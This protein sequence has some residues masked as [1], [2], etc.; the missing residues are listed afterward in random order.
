[1]EEH[2]RRPDSRSIWSD[3]AE[4]LV[5]HGV[6]HVFGLPGDDMAALAAL[7]ASG[8]TVHLVAD[9]RHAVYQAI[10]YG[11]LSGKVGVCLVGKGPAVTHAATGVLEAQTM[12]SPLVLLTSGL[13]PSRLGSRGF[14]E[15]DAVEVLRPIS[16]WTKRVGEPGAIQQDVDEAVWQ[17]LTGAPGAACL[18]IPEGMDSAGVTAGRAT[19]PLRRPVVPE[20][21]A[22]SGMLLDAQRPVLLVGGGCREAGVGGLVTELA[23]RLG[24]AILC[25]A[26]GR[27][28]VDESCPEFLGL[29][30]LYA[31]PAAAEVFAKA[32]LVVAL[33]S[34]LEETATYGWPGTVPPVLQVNRSIDDVSTRWPGAAVVADVGAVLRSWLSGPL[35]PVA[36]AAPRAAWRAAV[37]S[38]RDDLVNGLRDRRP[39]PSPAT[40]RVADVLAALEEVLPRERVSVHE[41]GLQDMWSYFFPTWSVGAGADCLVPSEQTPLGFGFGSA[42]G[43]ALAAGARPVVVIGGDGAFTAALSDLGTLA[44]VRHPLLLVVLSNGGFGWLEANLRT[45]AEEPEPLTAPVSFLRARRPI[46][47]VCAAYGITHLGCRQAGDLLQTVSEAWQRCTAQRPVVLEVEVALADVP[48]GMEELSGDFPLTDLLVEVAR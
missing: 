11:R 31:A 28:V 45:L 3:V 42:P 48:P 32:D 34:Q 46:G 10:G 12:R 38:A 23:R 1:M 30:G 15:L 17:A 4:R 35:G 33:G 8:I 26:S 7:Q 24:A 6:E 43:A 36:G 5:Q 27:G 2:G 9:Q 22:D 18:E 29:S 40:P 13:P 44:E 41:N 25:T 39:A 16:K 37:E 21:V 14:Q 47:A 19:L 20:V